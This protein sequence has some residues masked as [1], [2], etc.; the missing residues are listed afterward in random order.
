MPIVLV[1]TAYR[2]PTH[3]QAEIAVEGASVLECLEAV[4][5]KC[6]GFLSQILDASRVVHGFVKLFVNGQQID[7]SAL[8]RELAPQ[9]RLEVL[10]A[11]AGG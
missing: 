10:A 11:I 3:G 4:E 9:D 2:G 8:S 5:A 6:P 1:P 7:S